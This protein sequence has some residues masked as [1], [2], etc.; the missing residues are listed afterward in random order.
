[1]LFQRD[2]NKEYWFEE[3]CYILELLND[4]AD[5]SVSI[6]RARVPKRGTTAWHRLRDTTERYV[7]LEGEGEV[8]IGDEAPQRAGPGDV[9]VIPPMV[10]QCIRNTG[11]EDLVFLAICTPRFER[12]NY[13]EG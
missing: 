6:A 9:V 13:V 4:P 7:I 5:P 10:R 11:E 1:M 3:G 2:E 12:E 8:G